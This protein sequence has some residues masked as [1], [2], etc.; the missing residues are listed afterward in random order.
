MRSL[1]LSGFLHLVGYS[2][3]HLCWYSGIIS[4]FVWLSNIPLHHVFSPHSS[5][6]EHSGCFRVLA[7]VNSA[8]VNID[9]VCLN[10]SFIWIYAQE[11]NCRIIQQFCFSFS[12]E[13]PLMVLNGLE[14]P[15]NAP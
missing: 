12:H 3:V 6:G 9:I 1:S 10:C 7:I 15:A 13:P 5:V 4:F 14:A 2:L 8:A 11:W